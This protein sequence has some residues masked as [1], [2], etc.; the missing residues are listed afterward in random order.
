MLG[1]DTHLLF[2]LSAN[3]A[4]FSPTSTPACTPST[5]NDDDDDDDDLSLIHI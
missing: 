2:S 5:G 4:A 1:V 3:R